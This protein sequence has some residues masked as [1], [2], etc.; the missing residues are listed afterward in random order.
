MR[1]LLGQGGMGEVYLAYDSRLRRQVA[2]KLLPL[3]FTENRVRLSRF[4]REAFAASSLNHPNILTIHEIGQQ[5]D[6]HFIATEYVEGESL[7]QRLRRKPFELRESLAIV[8]QVA[9]A[10]AAAHEAGIVH[11]DIKPEN[12]MLRRDGYVKV[13][14]FGLAKLAV[15]SSPSEVTPEAPTVPHV[16]KTDPGV[17]MGTASYMSPEQA[18]GL[19]VDGRTDIWS[20]GTVLYELVAGRLPFEGPTSTDVIATIL[21]Q[22]PP[23][24]LLYR[25]DVPAE[26]ER[27][28][29]KALTKERE[30]R[31]Q[32]ARDLSVDLKRLKQRL[33][34]DAELERSVTPDA[35]SKRS[36]PATESD[37]VAPS[38]T[39]AHVA[40][41]VS[42][43]EYVAGEIKRHKLA[44]LLLAALIVVGAAAAAGYYKF[45]GSRSQAITSIAVLPFKNES[46]DANADY[47]S[48]GISESLIDKL[49]Q[50]PELKVIARSS[51]FKYKGKDFDAQEVAKTLG[52]GAILSGRVIERGDQLQV[53]A[54][55]INTSDKTQLWGEQYTRK[56]TDVQAVQEEI[57]GAI[58][59]RLR[60]RL[61]GADLQQ[62]S[63]RSTTNPEAY[64]LYLNGVYYRRKSNESLPSA[65]NYFNQAVALDPKFALAWVGIS[66]A[67]RT[68]GGMGTMEPKVAMPKARA[69]I[70]KAVEL[71]EQ[72]ADA[73]RAQADL[74]MFEWDWSGAERE[75]KRAFELNPNL[76]EAHSSYAGLLWRLGRPE[77]SLPEVRRAEELDPL[78]L[79]HR[80]REGAAFYVARR[81]DEAIQ[82][83]ESVLKL[84]PDNPTAL[85]YRAYAYDGKGMYKEAIT[86]YQKLI[87]TQIEARASHQCFLG[88]ALAQAGKRNEA[89]A[90]LEKLKTTKEYVSPTELA[91]LYAGL[92]DKEA[93]FTLLEKAYAVHDLELQYLKCEPHFDSL[94]TD[95]R[96]I[97]LIKKVG[98]PV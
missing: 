3:E 50:L 17:V 26:L 97:E 56:L 52:V 63:K 90:V 72:L 64:Q 38:T 9:E 84:A 47:L 20:L 6:H 21:H 15:E 1:S 16:L 33:E 85:V 86:E 34:L 25:S 94:Q 95:P 5:N 31:F 11:R 65:L 66:D 53:R 70:N 71:D 67:Y 74:M 32:L 40:H 73:H 23:S 27:I 75:F 81:Y 43:A 98:L 35:E 69:A 8:I 68:L 13:L 60:V 36:G 89:L 37:T 2:I 41:T 48:D 39:E 18:R 29:E 12:V 87:S 44:A 42:S 4:E 10:L 28:V 78:D 58:S 46:G 59:E 88:Y 19:E 22:E 93:A 45:F 51:A 77:E 55:L 92:G 57:A 61:T 7:R 91:V 54:E 83:F 24:L 14:D 30:E 76:A 49:S 96:Y 79:R 62:L 82:T 80:I